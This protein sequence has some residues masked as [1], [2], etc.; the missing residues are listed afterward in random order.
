LGPAF[1]AVG[2]GIAALLEATTASRYQL[3]GTQLQFV[4][5]LAV[6]ITVV[7]GFE[8]GMSWA[9]VGGLMAD[10]LTLRPLGSTVFELLVVVGATDIS[11]PIMSRARYPGCI[12]AVLILTPIY[13]VI[14]D[15]V[16]VLLQP[17]A[18]TLRISSL[19]IAALA[20]AVLAAVITPLVIGLKRRAERR[21]QVLW[22]R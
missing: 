20:N 1:A 2:A 15:I 14:S 13:L 9:F 6:A 17:P 3:A 12:V 22:W 18:P 7:F 16:A 8:E 5:V 11:V 10:F 4:L 19:I 21:E